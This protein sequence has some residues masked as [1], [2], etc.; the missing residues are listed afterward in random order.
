M[1]AVELLEDQHKEA[2][3]LMKKLE[4]SKPGATRKQ[5][6]HKLRAA[7]IAHMVIEEEL[8][9]PSV[10]AATSKDGEPI[11][12]GYEEHVVARGAL[13]R[14]AHGLGQERLFQV[15]I[16]VLKELIEH[17]IKEER[18]SILPMAKKAMSKQELSDLGM[19][20]EKRFDAVEGSTELGS[21][22]DRR[23]TARTQR[24]LSA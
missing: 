5:T 13:E 21:E 24:A 1:N 9:Y 6:F 16:G 22:L 10:L 18:S 2:L 12:E 11:A 15:R 20:M 7:L 8:F 4:D 23:A 14:C 17:H 3:S 19:L